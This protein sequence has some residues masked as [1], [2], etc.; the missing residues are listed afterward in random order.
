MTDQVRTAVA[1]LVAVGVVLL[2]AGLRQQPAAGT[3]RP[4][5][6]RCGGS[7]CRRPIPAELKDL[8]ARDLYWRS[9]AL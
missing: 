1:S 9:F 3:A 2:T 7:G 8:S 5:R 4:Q 6:G